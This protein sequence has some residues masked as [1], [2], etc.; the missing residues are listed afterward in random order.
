MCGISVI[1]WITS[2]SQVCY[3]SIISE[4]QYPLYHTCITSIYQSYHIP[5]HQS[6]VC[7]KSIISESQ[8]PLYHMYHKYIPFISHPI[9]SITTIITPL[10]CVGNTSRFSCSRWNS[11]IIRR[12]RPN[13]SHSA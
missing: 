7:Y 3:K 11:A 10:T 5:S 13:S 2:E 12:F 9:T 4:S 1:R 6:Q 8:Y